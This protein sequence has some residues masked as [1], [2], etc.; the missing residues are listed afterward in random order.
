LT[1]RGLELHPTRHSVSS[2]ETIQT[3]QNQTSNLTLE[4]R[5][6]KLDDLDVTPPRHGLT[7]PSID[8][9][10]RTPSPHDGID[11]IDAYF[12]SEYLV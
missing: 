4:S 10:K 12:D 2:M 8:S 7:T 1:P 9:G 6:S 5:A 11:L 3:I